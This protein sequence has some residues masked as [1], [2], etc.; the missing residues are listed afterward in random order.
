MT[1]GCLAVYGSLCDEWL[2]G[3]VLAVAPP[4]HP[5][6]MDSVYNSSASSSSGSIADPM[7]TAQLSGAVVALHNPPME[8][9]GSTLPVM[10]ISRLVLI[11][12]TGV[13]RQRH[14]TWRARNQ[15]VDVASIG[16]AVAVSGVGRVT[17]GRVLS[18][19]SHT[20]A[21]CGALA[22]R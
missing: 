3:S 12:S 21:W 6:A 2:G 16:A 18:I 10:S 22:R 19:K 20:P 1:D 5:L 11:D 15:S 9:R 17:M 8:D 13:Q 7:L 14:M 4:P